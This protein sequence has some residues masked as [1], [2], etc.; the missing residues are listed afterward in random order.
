MSPVEGSAIP[1]GKYP[2]AVGRASA[3]DIDRTKAK[4]LGVA[5][6]DLFDA[7]QTYLGSAYVNDF[8]FLNRA[9]RV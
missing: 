6:N 4:S 8:D 5:L 1:I 2:G 9:Y 7:L 3:T